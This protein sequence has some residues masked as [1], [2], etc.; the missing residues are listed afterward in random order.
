MS[1]ELRD[2]KR[3][4]EDDGWEE[5]PES[6]SLRTSN[7]GDQV[8]A[9]I[10]RGDWGGVIRLLEAGA[11]P[12]DMGG[13]GVLSA[14]LKTAPIE[15][16]TAL[17]RAGGT[18]TYPPSFCGGYYRENY[19]VFASK[20]CGNSY[21]NPIRGYK[22]DEMLR[23]VQLLLSHGAPITNGPEIL[24]S[25]VGQ[26][27][28]WG[29]VGQDTRWGIN[30]TLLVSLVNAL[31]QYGGGIR[32]QDVRLVVYQRNQKGFDMYEEAY[33]R[34][35]PLLPLLTGLGQGGNT[36]LGALSRHTLYTRD[37]L[38]AVKRLTKNQ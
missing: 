7:G 9:A 14:L 12:D 18:L 38:R 5:G 20:F 26:D 37:V 32:P 33:R 11:S 21:V 28:R 8:L 15:V 23:I 2:N 6:K 16:I 22:V 27:D 31:N 4:R 17:V 13:S 19:P 3:G 29:I 34:D 25:I 30:P 1:I 36:A 35:D 24:R 10:G